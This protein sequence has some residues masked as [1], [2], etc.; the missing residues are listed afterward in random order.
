MIF[1]LCASRSTYPQ[2]ILIL[3][4]SIENEADIK[5]YTSIAQAKLGVK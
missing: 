2:A 5:F 3:E 1:Y 4:L